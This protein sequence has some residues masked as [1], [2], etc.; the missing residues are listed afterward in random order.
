MKK[1]VSRM[2]AAGAMAVSISSVAPL[3]TARAQALQG[4]NPILGGGALRDCRDTAQEDYYC[5]VDDTLNNDSAALGASA[6]LLAQRCLVP[7][8]AQVPLNIVVECASQELKDFFA[9]LTP[10]PPAPPAKR[11]S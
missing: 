8:N 5:C 11:K 7:S 4:G 6:D 9:C 3:S 10:P 1:L 2:F